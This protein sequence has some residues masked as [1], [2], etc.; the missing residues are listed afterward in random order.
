MRFWPQNKA[1]NVPVT[2]NGPKG[3]S[4]FK[5]FLPEITNPN[6]I[7]A[8]IKKAK[9]KATKILGKPRKRPIKKAN[10]I[11]PIPSQRPREIKTIARKKIA[12]P[13]AL[14]IENLKIDI[15]NMRQN[16]ED[17]AIT[18]AEKQAQIDKLKLLKIN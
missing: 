11:S 1:R 6:P 5:V 8:P 3:T 14:R 15:Q 10:F 12:A 9:N 4:D 7:I 17:I 18:I 2:R 16:R 13:I